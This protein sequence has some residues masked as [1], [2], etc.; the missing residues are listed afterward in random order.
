MVRP[1]CAHREPTAPFAAHEV[2]TQAKV[3]LTLETLATARPSLRMRKRLM[4]MKGDPRGNRR[5]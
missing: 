4:T 2:K 5:G 3:R 1:S